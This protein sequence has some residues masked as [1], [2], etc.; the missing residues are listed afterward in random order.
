MSGKLMLM[1]EVSVVFTSRGRPESLKAA[2]GSLLDHAVQPDDVEVI[3]AIDPDDLA[4]KESINLPSQARFWVA[5]ER[6]GY[7]QLHVYLNELAV[8]AL[9][10]WCQ[11]WNDD[12]RMQTRGWDE[13]ISGHR[14][15]ILWPFANHVHHA[16]IAPA[17]PR[18]WSDAIGHVSPTTHMDTYLQRLG[19]QLGRHDRVAIEVVHDRADVTGNHDDATY[20]EGRKLL[21]SE[22]MAPGFDAA[23]MHAQLDIDASIIRELL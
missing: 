3:V 9:S 10:P 17:W 18:A 15:A 4:Y 19:E 2:I 12:M 1:P 16:N 14:P 13:V 8:M 20:A 6:Y 22:G 23:A 5:P 11:W 21:G 7:N